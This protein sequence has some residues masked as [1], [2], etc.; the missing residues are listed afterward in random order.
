LTG[1]GILIV[2]L[3]IYDLVSLHR[4]HRSTMWAAPLT[5]VVNALAVPIGMTSVW[6]AFAAMVNRTLGSYL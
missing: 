1:L 5:F 2:L 3:I 6:H 4:I